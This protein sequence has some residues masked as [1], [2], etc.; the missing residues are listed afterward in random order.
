MFW[1]EQFTAQSAWRNIS[2]T[3]ASCS[4][5][6]TSRNRWKHDTK[7]TMLLLFWG[8]WKTHQTQSTSFWYGFLNLNA[9]RLSFVVFRG[10]TKCRN[11][12]QLFDNKSLSKGVENVRFFVCYFVVSKWNEYLIFGRVWK[13]AFFVENLHNVAWWSSCS[14]TYF[15]MWWYKNLFYRILFHCIAVMKSVRAIA[16]NCLTINNL[17]FVLNWE[18]VIENESFD[19]CF[20][21]IPLFS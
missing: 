2:E 14:D 16:N 1:F 7:G 12:V 19:C 13:A 4:I 18:S 9:M 21:V 17:Y 20:F 8:V 5:S 10:S 11:L 15:A 6:E 3:R